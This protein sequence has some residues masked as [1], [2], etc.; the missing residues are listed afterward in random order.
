V[1]PA[2]QSEKH[3]GPNEV[4]I[5]GKRP[6]ILKRA[7]IGSENSLS[8]ETSNSMISATEGTKA[9]LNCQADVARIQGLRLNCVTA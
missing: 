4:K 3:A 9:E 7:K 6:I 8:C 2:E 5:L 1:L